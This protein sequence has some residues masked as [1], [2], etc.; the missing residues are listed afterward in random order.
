MALLNGRWASTK[1]GDSP[2]IG[3]SFIYIKDGCGV[4]FGRQPGAVELNRVAKETEG[5]IGHSQPSLW[6]EAQRCRLW[7]S[8]GREE[9][10]TGARREPKARALCW[11]VHWRE[12]LMVDGQE[13]FSQQRYLHLFA[14]VWPWDLQTFNENP[15]KSNSL[16]YLVD[17]ES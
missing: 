17:W 11:E 5:R 12:I 4:Q 6:R 16:V 8:K 3:P 10:E 9:E 15:D 1:I 2:V 7:K 13:D 14:V